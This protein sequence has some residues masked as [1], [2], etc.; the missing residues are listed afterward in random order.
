MQVKPTNYSGHF[1]VKFK[2][3][4]SATQRKYCRPI[5]TL[6][7]NVMFHV[8]ISFSVF[9]SLKFWLSLSL[10]GS[11]FSRRADKKYS[12]G[13]PRRSL[14]GTVFISFTSD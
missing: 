6:C 8:G 13:A 7:V 3:I 14:P 11:R 5:T 2:M 10:I 9:D 12:Y 4:A 1:T